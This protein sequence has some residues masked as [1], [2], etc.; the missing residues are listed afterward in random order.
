MVENTFKN[1][2]W[3]KFICRGTNTED[4]A[5]RNNEALE[6]LKPSAKNYSMC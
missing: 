2:N 6:T 4:L 5:G 3:L 1:S